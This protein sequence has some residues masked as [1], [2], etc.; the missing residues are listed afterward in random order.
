MAASRPTSGFA[1]APRP[2]VAFWPTAIL[3]SASVIRSACASVFTAMNSTPRKP[4]S[5]MRLTAFVPPPP[6]PTTLMT[7]RY[8]PPVSF[9]DTDSPSLGQTQTATPRRGRRVRRSPYRNA[10]SARRRPSRGFLSG[11]GGIVAGRM[12]LAQPR[13][14]RVPAA[15]HDGGSRGGRNIGV[16]E[17]GAVR[18]RRIAVQHP[19]GR[20]QLV[21]QLQGRP[22]DDV[23]AAAQA[24]DDPSLRDDLHVGDAR[25]EIPRTSRERIEGGL[26]RGRVNPAPWDRAFALR[27]HA[28]QHGH[29]VPPAEDAQHAAACGQEP[30]IAPRADRQ[31]DGPLGD[32]A[33]AQRM[34]EVAIDACEPDRR[35][36]LDL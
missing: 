1:P 4:L 20:A 30:P 9:I 27:P 23:E 12:L 5:T 6:T 19:R 3:T 33:Y 11:L 17:L 32:D 25:A 2:R 7:A 18:G 21:A 16:D 34:R 10:P 22:E 36:L 29:R 28:R 31:R 15:R 8:D 14:G 35:H 24:H 26:R 13:G